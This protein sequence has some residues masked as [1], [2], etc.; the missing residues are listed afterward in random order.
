M[1]TVGSS[2]GF[3]RRLVSVARLSGPL[4]LPLCT[5]RVDAAGVTIPQM[6]AL[7]LGRL[8]LPPPSSSRGC[9]KG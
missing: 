3:G 5:L 4:S 7:A 9:L 1:E 8:L 6:K 2:L